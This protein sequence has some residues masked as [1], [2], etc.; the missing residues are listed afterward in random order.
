MRYPYIRILYVEA[1]GSSPRKLGRQRS[2]ILSLHAEK[3]G[4]WRNAIGLRDPKAKLK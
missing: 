1:S 3:H 4:A 2:S